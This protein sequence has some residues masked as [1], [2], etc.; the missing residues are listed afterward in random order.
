MH[1]DLRY[2]VLNI[3]KSEENTTLFDLCPS[4]SNSVPS[5]F[6]LVSPGPFPASEAGAGASL[7][8][9]HPL[10]SGQAAA[11]Q[12]LVSA[13]GC[14]WFL[15]RAM[16]LHSRCLA[17]D[18]RAA[19]A[20]GYPGCSPKAPLLLP[21]QSQLGFGILIP[22]FKTQMRIRFPGQTRKRPDDWI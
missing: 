2:P 17:T 1:S 15:V 16:L 5:Q 10:L 14:A 4:A 18:A 11:G 13:G 22:W 12:P 3:N 20:P 19:C 7:P 9:C 6:S 8:R 21:Q